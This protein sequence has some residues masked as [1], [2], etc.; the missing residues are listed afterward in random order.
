MARHYKHRMYTHTKK[1]SILQLHGAVSNY[2]YLP[3][4]LKQT[5]SHRLGLCRFILIHMIILWS[6]EAISKIH[7]LFVIIVPF[8]KNLL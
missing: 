4:R 5:W 6:D 8:R 1:P 3:A 2:N 7:L